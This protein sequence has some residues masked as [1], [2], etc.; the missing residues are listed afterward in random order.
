MKHGWPRVVFGYL[1][2]AILIGTIWHWHWHT[3][4]DHLRTIGIGVLVIPPG[5]LLFLF[6]ILSI[7]NRKR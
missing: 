2:L 4:V 3:L 1:L 6:C 5:I 7:P